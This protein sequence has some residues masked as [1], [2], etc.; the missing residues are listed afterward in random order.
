M[1][2]ADLVVVF[3]S[4]VMVSIVV[5]EIVVVLKCTTCFVVVLFLQFEKYHPWEIRA[6][7]RQWCYVGQIGSRT[8]NRDKIGTSGI[9]VPRWFTSV[10]Q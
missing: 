2:D 8:I 9:L 1:N 4:F 5:V 7:V 10:R 6:R 3:V